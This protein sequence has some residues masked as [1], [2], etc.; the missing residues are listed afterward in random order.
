MEEALSFPVDVWRALGGQPG[1]VCRSLFGRVDGQQLRLEVKRELRSELETARSMWAFDFEED[2]P[3]EGALQWE[4]LASCEVPAFYRP[5]VHGGPR[6][7][8][9][10]PPGPVSEAQEESVSSR[11]AA[12]PPQATR[13][14]K[15]K[16]S[17]ITD[18]YALKRS[19]GRPGSE[20]KP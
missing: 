3:V 18:F 6:H 4:A 10:N 19:L 2:R 20:S 16:Q 8:L 14:R 12:D 13:G 9:P 11:Q 7:G 15:R 17:V 5:C 1:K